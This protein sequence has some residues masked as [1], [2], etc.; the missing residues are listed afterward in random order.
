MP[1]HH[2]PLAS[3]QAGRSPRKLDALLA[4]ELLPIDPNIGTR[5]EFRNDAVEVDNDIPL[6]GAVCVI[7]RADTDD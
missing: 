7:D 3:R 2:Y 5:A 4:S 6:V 1:L